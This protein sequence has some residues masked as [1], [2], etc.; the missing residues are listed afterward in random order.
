MASLDIPASPERI[1]VDEL[2]LKLQ[3]TPIRGSTS[4][5]LRSAPTPARTCKLSWWARGGENE[6]SATTR[7]P[8]AD[9]AGVARPRIHGNRRD[10]G[11]PR[12]T[13]SVDKHISAR[14]SCGCSLPSGGQHRRRAWH[15]RPAFTERLPS[16]SG[17]KLDDIVALS[18][19][20]VRA[21]GHPV[22]RRRYNRSVRRSPLSRPCCCR[23]CLDS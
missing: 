21:G 7:Q 6:G 17:Q 18:D 5:A 20:R 1:K 10:S 3:N 16:F 23:A 9:L 15:A 13:G 4:W 14:R 8:E 11:I 19:L 12:Y 2:S 22:A